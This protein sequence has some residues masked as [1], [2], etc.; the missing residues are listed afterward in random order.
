MRTCCA[1]SIRKAVRSPLI[2]SASFLGSAGPVYS[3]RLLR[4]SG[5]NRL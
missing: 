2:T 3:G 4:P 5:V 1:L